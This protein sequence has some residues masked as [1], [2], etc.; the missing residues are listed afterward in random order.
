[1]DFE[2][3]DDTSF[4]LVGRHQDAG[5]GGCH[6]GLRFDEPRVGPSDC[7][8]CHVDVHLGNLSDNCAGC[9]NEVSYNDVAG[10]SIH[11]RTAFPLTGAHLQLTC[12]SCHVDDRGSA[13]SPLDSDCFSC[14]A[15]DYE[16]AQSLDHT[17]LAFST[18]CE[19]CHNTLGWGGGPF[20]HLAASGSFDLVGT[21]TIIRCEACHVMPGLA[22]KY[23]PA[24]QNDCLTCHEQ[25]YQR[26]HAGSGFPTECLNCHDQNSWGGAVIVAAQHDAIF[27]IF[28]G[29][30]QGKWNND[31]SVCHIVP[32]NQQ[33]FSCLNCHQHSQARMNDAHNEVGGYSYISTLCY[34]CHPRGRSD[35]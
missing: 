19:E 23:Q 10:V 27:P 15:A 26:K 14:H 11:T 33:V 31:C 22:L 34:E 21:H 2:H 35:D 4:P 29:P 17:A 16:D 6:L 18:T 24:G 25:D 3:D 7:G 13:Y 32:N 5:C 8:A 20:N 1:M 12:E 28:S 30:H 9:H